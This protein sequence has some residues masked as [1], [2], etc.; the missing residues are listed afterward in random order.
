MKTENLEW[1]DVAER[2]VLYLDIGGFKDRV[3]F[4]KTSELRKSLL[5]FRNKK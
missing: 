4:E 1:Q 2:F 3:R 5:D